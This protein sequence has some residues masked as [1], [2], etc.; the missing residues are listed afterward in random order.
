MAGGKTELPLANAGARVD[1]SP[2][3]KG[4]PPLSKARPAGRRRW[5]ERPRVAADP[6]TS[7]GVNDSEERA[8]WDARDFSSNHPML[9]MPDT[10]PIAKYL[11]CKLRGHTFSS[12]AH[13]YDVEV[14]CQRCGTQRLQAFDDAGCITRRTYCFPPGFHQKPQ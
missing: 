14:V 13:D 2:G 1:D 8:F 9:S 3:R 5:R 10:D 7:T 4:V 11:P 12:P 6:G